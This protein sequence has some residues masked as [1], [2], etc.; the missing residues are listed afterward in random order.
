[1]PTTA[2][3][4]TPRRLDRRDRGKIVFSVCTLVTR[5]DEYAE[6]VATFERGGFGA[7]D[8]EYLF[9]DNTG[10]NGADAYDGYNHFLTEAAGR[11]II[12]CHQDVL[13]LTDD[14]AVLEAR[15][16][17][18]DA[19]SPD[20]ALCGNAGGAGRGRRF[21]RISDPH[22]DDQRRGP[23]PSQVSSLDE[24]FILV[25]R[26]A[27]L[28]LSHDIG[29]FHLYGPDLCILADILGRSAWVIDFHLRHKSGG[30]VGPD[31]NACR[32][33]LVAKYRRALRT[34]WIT[35]SCTQLLL[36]GTSL[37]VSATEFARNAKVRLEGRGGTLG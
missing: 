37:L 2:S 32:S 31:F 35:T 1:M 33:V 15:L 24:N 36:S 17:E 21:A 30:T 10:A 9:L 18:L 8:C 14:R 6:M 25:R 4:V 23:F 27:N 28:A 5:P 3:T 11:Y 34:R 19:I 26:D 12:L 20:W 29:G 16:A 7:D 13:L 22:G